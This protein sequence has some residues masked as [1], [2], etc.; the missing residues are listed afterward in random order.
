MIRAEVFDDERFA[1]IQFDA[2]SWFEQ[3]SNDK[4]VSLAGCDWGGDYTGDEVAEFV[5]DINPEINALFIYIEA[6][7][8][9]RSPGF[10]YHV[11]QQDTLLGFECHV[12]QQDALNWLK[13]NRDSAYERVTLSFNKPK[14][15]KTTIKLEI[16]SEESIVGCNL[17]RIAHEITSGGWSGDWN[18][19]KTEDLYGKDAANAII[20]QGSEPEFFAITEDGE[21]NEGI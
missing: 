9:L 4:I 19:E 7:N 6:Y 17:R 13:E 5:R 11:D 20:A 10:E 18:V 1:T 12:D 16:L 2:T 8:R 14:I 3:A 21:R 15:V